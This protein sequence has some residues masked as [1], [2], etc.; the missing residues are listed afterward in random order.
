VF[1]GNTVAVGTHTITVTPGT[2]LI[3]VQ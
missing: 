2:G 1:P 3:Q